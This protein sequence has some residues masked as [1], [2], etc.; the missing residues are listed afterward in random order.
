M[1]NVT[2]LPWSRSLT[3]DDL[4][5]IPEDGHRYELVDGALVVTPSPAMRHQRASGR[6]FVALVQAC[7]AGLEVFAAPFDVVLT[8]DSVLQPDLLVARQADLT[9][10]NLPGAPVL[11]VEILSPS[12]RRIDLLLKRSRYESAGCPN[13]WVIDPDEPSVIA[14]RLENNRYVESG[15]TSG[16]D[17]LT[18]TSP[19]AVTIVP[20]DLVV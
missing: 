9:D 12:T 13:Y 14:W 10:A 4:D 11:A 3:R 2:M 1:A 20:A 17:R 16:S 15:R 8:D 6:L 7:P 18:L 19:F 5:G